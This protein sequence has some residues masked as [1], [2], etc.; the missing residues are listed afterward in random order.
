[1]KIGL[2]TDGLG[3]LGFE[4]LLETAA[5]MGIECLEPGTGNWSPAPHISLDRLLEEPAARTEL[6]AKVRDHGLS[7]SALNCSGNQ[8]APGTTGEQHADVVRKTLRL[9]SLLELDRVVMM[10]GLPGGPGDANPNWIITAWPPENAEI[11]RWQWQ[12]VAIPYWRDLAAEARNLGV[13]RIALELH[14]GQ[15]AYSAETLLQLR[16]AAGEAVGANLDPSHIFWMGGDPI[17]LV[18]ALGDAIFNVHAKDTRIE[19]RRAAVN[20]LLESK[21]NAR[22]AERSWNYAT[23]GYGHDE[24]WWRRFVAALRAVGYDDVLS[25]EHEDYVAGRVEGIRKAVQLLQS[26]LL[27]ETSDYADPVPAAG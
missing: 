27:R 21:P 6:L 15:L 8:L 11:L 23:L 22:V 25:I 1:M 14:G 5:E 16:D 7:I 20:T 19:P 26:V 12:E 18:Y 2:T 9:A 24:G 4:E 17:E 10:S 13:R 3:H